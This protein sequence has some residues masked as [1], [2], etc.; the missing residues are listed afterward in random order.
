MCRTRAIELLLGRGEYKLL[1]GMFFVDYPVSAVPPIHLLAILS[2]QI[3]EGTYPWSLEELDV[4]LPYLST[5][6]I[7]A[8]LS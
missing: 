4:I 7:S 8:T 1:F 6:S 2:D 3:T 5:G